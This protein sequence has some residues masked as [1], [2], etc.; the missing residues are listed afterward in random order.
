MSN[1]I[2]TASIVLVLTIFMTGCGRTYQIKGRVVFLPQL[3]SADGIIAEIT[4]EPIPSG[5]E[6][7][8][9]AKVRMI[10]ELNKEGRPVE[11]TVW[12]QATL[13]DANSYFEI[14]DYAEP[15]DNVPVGLEVSKDGYKTVFTT[16]IDYVEKDKGDKLQLFFVVLS[17]SAS[18]N[19]FDQTAP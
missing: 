13:T 5:G 16:Y 6:S 9:G 7:I 17:R 11:N 4:G 3:G 1:R 8:A 18:G 10:H 2:L 12:Q 14:S 19:S 15:Y